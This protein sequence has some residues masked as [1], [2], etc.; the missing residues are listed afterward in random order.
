MSAAFRFAKISRGHAQVV[1]ADGKLLYGVVRRRW[2]GGMYW[3]A[4]VNQPAGDYPARRTTHTT[5]LC[6]AAEVAHVAKLL[7]YKLPV[8]RPRGAAAL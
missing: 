6:A 8:A 4:V 2:A 1:S 3:E 5:R 7:G